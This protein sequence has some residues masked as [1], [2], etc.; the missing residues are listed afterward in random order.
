MSQAT[1]QC[2][3]PDPELD[4]A[5]QALRRVNFDWCV[6]LRDV[7]IDNPGDVPLLH[8]NLREDFRAQL[9]AL[10]NT[11][12]SPLGWP[13][14]GSGGTGKTHLL[15]FLRHETI[16]REGVFIL[17]D[18]TDVR[19]FW[20]NL[21]Q[22]YVDSLHERS[23]N[24][25]TQQQVVLQ[26][27]L[28]KICPKQPLEKTLNA[29]THSSGKTLKKNINTILSFLQKHDHHALQ[30]QDAVRAICCLNSTSFEIQTVG[31]TWLQGQPLEDDARRDFGFCNPAPSCRD[32]VKSLSWYLGL[33]S[34]TVVCFDQLDPIVHQTAV[35]SPGQLEEAEQ[36]TA[37]SIVQQIGTGLA[38]MGELF[39]TFTVVTCV[40]TTWD[41]LAK[42]VLRTN[43][44]RFKSEPLALN[45]PKTS[46]FAERFLFSRL[47]TAYREAGW[48]PP[49]PTWPFENSAIAQL[50]N[51]TPREIL[52]KCEDQ[53]RAMLNAGQVWDVTDF[54]TPTVPNPGKPDPVQDALREMDQR[55]EHLKQGVDVDQLLQDRY[56]DLR[57]APLYVAAFK[58]LTIEKAALIPAHVDALVDEDFPGGENSRPLHARLRL[59]FHQ[60]NSREE[61]YCVRG[62]EW[63]NARAYQNRLR[64]ALTQSGIDRDLPFR[65]LT[66]VRTTDSPGGK[67]TAELNDSL[68]TANG[69][70]YR[71]TD[72]ELRSLDAL[73]HL[74][75]E[76]DPALHDWLQSRLPVSHMRPLVESLVQGSLLVQDPPSPGQGEISPLNPDPQP[77]G[78]DVD[79]GPG[80]PVKDP[81]PVSPP[82]TAKKKKLSPKKSTGNQKPIDRKQQSELPLGQRVNSFSSNPTVAIPTKVLA[83]HTIIL[84]GAGSGKTVTVRRIVEEAALAGIPSIVVDC[85]QDMCTFDERRSAASPHWGSGDDEKAEQFLKSTEMVVYTPGKSSGRPL[86][87]EPIPDLSPRDDPD[88]LE[89]AVGMMKGFL[90]TIVAPGNQKSLQKQGILAASLMFFAKH[91]T[92]TTL[93]RYIDLL[94]AL[95]EEAQIGINKETDLAKEMADS[96]RIQVA[97]DP[98][99][100]SGGTPLDP[101]I[102]FGDDAPS[103]KTRISAI[104][105][106]GLPALEQQRSF[107]NQLA[108][109]L[110]AWIKK[111]PHPPNGRALRG[112]LVIDEAKDFVPAVK[113]SVCKDSMMRLAAQ[114]RKYKLGLVFATQHPKDIDTKIVGNCATQ[115][116]GRI[117]SPA[118]LDTAKTLL[119]NQGM[120]SPNLSSQKTG[121]FYVNF[122]DGML[123]APTQIQ[124]PDSLTASRQLDEGEV[125][126]KTRPS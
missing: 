96:L 46:E 12:K 21:L 85:A 92:P 88:E 116:F 25:Q 59:V 78:T 115:F 86:T 112:L 121:Q 82:V 104:S 67:V 70:I 122:P 72:D 101:R 23:E 68:A 75:Q 103:E 113:S 26:R 13:I 37:K 91:V 77:S 39:W 32:I 117:V 83:K 52:Q 97:Q 19:D 81:E 56:E 106:I 66:I 43:L 111:N 53:R 45:K 4:A 99:L 61:H 47:G 10:K 55:F 35:T 60:D 94:D 73:N 29:L 24:Q 123:T 57:L 95:P 84:G 110:F 16:T 3:V 107:L 33:V 2:S 15:S 89:A 17:V 119:Q 90:E 71:I 98:L 48:Q 38:D 50:A 11:R 120:A 44:A 1:I 20:G 5:L 65:H 118:S 62:L 93:E 109:L 69:R 114:A 74:L 126:S 9:D 22:G 80:I 6:R 34:P 49:F 54:G 14:V 27:F 79:S 124:V 42:L 36:N 30:H 87:L 105:L 40:E 8:E 31:W 7:W 63:A 108:M 64:A 51:E 28:R 18:M 76:N 41:L 58:C 100:K 125:L 102:L